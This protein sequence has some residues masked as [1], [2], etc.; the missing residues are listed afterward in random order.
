MGADLSS[1]RANVEK[2]KRSMAAK[3]ANQTRNIRRKKAKTAYSFRM[4]IY[5]GNR[6]GLGFRYRIS[7]TGKMND[8][9]IKAYYN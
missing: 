6:I 3:K 2:Q 8:E 4:S 9:Q 5:V 1:L 7:S